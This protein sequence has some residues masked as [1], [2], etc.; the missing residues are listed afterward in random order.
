LLSNAL[1]FTKVGSIRLSLTFI[2]DELN[3]EVTDTGVGM[4]ADQQ[5]IVQG[6]GFG[7]AV[8]QEAIAF[9]NGHI[10]FQSA[11]GQGT[12]IS[13]RI[14]IESAMS[15]YSAPFSDGEHLVVNMI[16]E[17][18]LAS[19]ITEV[20]T[21]MRYSVQIIQTG[22][23][24]VELCAK[25]RVDSVFAECGGSAWLQLRHA[26]AR[27]EKPPIICGVGETGEE[28]VILVYPIVPSAI[29]IFMNGVRY[30]QTGI[31][32]KTPTEEKPSRVLV[33]EDNKTNQ[34]VMQKILS[35]IGCTFEIAEN[36]Q[37]AIDV[38]ERDNFDMVFMD[39]QM[40]VL[41]GI[42]ATR[43]IRKCGKSY[44]SIPIVALTASAVEGDEKT[45]REAGMDGYLAKPVRIQQ[46]KTAI[47]KFHS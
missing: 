17:P 44:S 18:N 35:N 12:T 7:L 3:L 5:L 31:Q 23:E 38:L 27:I 9:M 2:D 39:C 37:E 1:K 21:R 40:P 42:E 6:A 29:E 10:N 24:F 8:V 30:R 34:F 11:V 41:D 47:G 14:P 20:L 25:H 13:C 36:G 19:L 32:I 15:P 22:E 43:I 16:T 4:T 46:I 28:G 26:I 33:V 45:C